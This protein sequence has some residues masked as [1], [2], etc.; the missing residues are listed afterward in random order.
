MQLDHKFY[1]YCKMDINDVC[2]VCKQTNDDMLMLS[3]VHNPCVNCAAS[4]YAEIVHIKNG[5]P[6]VKLLLIQVYVCEICGE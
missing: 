3:C 5:N 4:A 2:Q 6:N 1:F